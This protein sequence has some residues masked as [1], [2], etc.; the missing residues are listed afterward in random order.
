MNS[1]IKIINVPFSEGSLEK[2]KG[3][4][5]AGNSIKKEFLKNE[6]G[7]EFEFSEIIIPKNDFDESHKEIFRQGLKNLRKTKQT[8]F[9]GGDHSITFQLFQ[10]FRKKFSETKGNKKNKNIGLVIF[11]A[12]LDCYEYFKP[13]SHE[14]FLRVLIEDKKVNPENV[15]IIGVRKKYKKEIAFMK[16]LG[17]KKPEIISAVKIKNE[18]NKLK[19]INEK[20]QEFTAKLDHIYISIDIDAFD[21][22]IAPGTGYL[23]RN[24]L[25]YKEFETIYAS[26]AETKKIRAIDLVE[27]N[28][29]KDRKNKTVKLGKKIIQSF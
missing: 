22:K 16:K 23:E 2:N 5:L 3:C 20:I 25:S 1:K 19:K 27:I 11:D 29:L 17:K 4:E 10:A 7:H 13:V 9:I 8:V 18:K 24:G 26:I 14:D 6:A 28:P 12:H 21:P 15:M